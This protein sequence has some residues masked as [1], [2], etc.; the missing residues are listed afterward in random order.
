MYDLKEMKY[1]NIVH[2]KWLHMIPGEQRFSSTESRGQSEGDTE[3][4]I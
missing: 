1:M 4:G 3:M 2:K